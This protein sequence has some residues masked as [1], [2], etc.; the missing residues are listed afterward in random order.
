MIRRFL[1]VLLGSLLAVC[2][3]SAE[4][5]DKLSA[6]ALEQAL[7]SLSVGG[8]AAIEQQDPRLAPIARSAELTRELY[9]VAGAVLTELAERNGGDPDRMSDMLAR[10]KM[11]PEGFLASLSPATRA[12]LSALAAKLR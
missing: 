11:D 5:L 10:G 8:G 2:S 6:A 4:P 12:R 7:G 9:D 3:A 1:L